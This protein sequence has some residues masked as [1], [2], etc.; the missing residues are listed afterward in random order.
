MDPVELSLELL[1]L[2]KSA[3]ALERV[4]TRLQR[5]DATLSTVQP[6]EL[7]RWISLLHSVSDKAFD[8]GQVLSAVRRDRRNHRRSLTKA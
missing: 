7:T 6:A 8:A 3:A 5:C 4:G 2:A 1:E